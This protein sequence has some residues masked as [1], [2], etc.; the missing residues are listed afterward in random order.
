MYPEELLDKKELKMHSK[1][2]LDHEFGLFF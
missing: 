1:D 2:T